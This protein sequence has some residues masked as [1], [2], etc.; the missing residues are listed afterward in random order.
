[1]TH[2]MVWIASV[3][4]SSWGLS[5]GG[6]VDLLPQQ[7]SSTVHPS[8]VHSLTV[9]TNGIEEAVETTLMATSYLPTSVPLQ[10]ISQTRS[11]LPW[12]W[13]GAGA[14]MGVGIGAYVLRK[15]NDARSP[16][17]FYPPTPE[18]SK[19]FQGDRPVTHS[20]RQANRQQQYLLP[21]VATKE[22]TVPQ[23]VSTKASRASVQ[24]THAQ[25][26]AKMPVVHAG[27]SAS[28]KRVEELV[29]SLQSREVK[30]RRQA[31][32]DLGQ[33]GAPDVI[34][35]LVNSM[36]TADSQQRSLI[37]AALS[38]IGTR[39]LMPL[40]QALILALQDNNGDVRKNAIREM[41]RLYMA[42]DQLNQI[43][44]HAMTDDDAEVRATAQWAFD[45]VQAMQARSDSQGIMPASR[46]RSHA[47]QTLQDGTGDM[48]RRENLDVRA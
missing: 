30:L 29:D 1:M 47:Q 4:L 22:S 46:P 18:S 34:Q 21:A 35:P 44:G 27:N 13:I 33:Q 38:E 16:Q 40:N 20:Q 2:P 15:T 19:E 8:D 6:D 42:M 5:A 28:G 32:W 37:L 43:L 36:S 14:A 31:I 25:K 26:M 17:M 3:L 45:Q 41:T 23:R 7:L 11:V 48:R 10:S 12:L 24:N 39:T 9:N